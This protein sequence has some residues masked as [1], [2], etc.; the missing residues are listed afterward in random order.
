MILSFLM[1]SRED[2]LLSCVSLY[3]TKLVLHSLFSTDSCLQS[4]LFFQNKEDFE[5]DLLV[6]PLVTQCFTDQAVRGG[7]ENKA[8][9]LDLGVCKRIA[10][11]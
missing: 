2:M 6:Q 1:P 5:G 11:R 4:G 3:V 9:F 10:L 7:L 8:C